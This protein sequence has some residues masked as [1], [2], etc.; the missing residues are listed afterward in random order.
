MTVYV[1]HM[2]RPFGRL[3]LSHM[4]ADTPDELHAM[5]KRI[6]IDRQHFQDWHRASFPHYDVCGAA[7]LAAI[8]YG[9]VAVDR[10]GLAEAMRRARPTWLETA[11]LA[12]ASNV[13][14]FRARR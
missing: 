1:D 5:A 13:V 8:H 7:R 4:I 12:D 14:P 9:A 6:G 3:R 10:R 2:R 11:K